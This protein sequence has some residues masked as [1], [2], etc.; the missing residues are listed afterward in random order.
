MNVSLLLIFLG[1]PQSS[2]FLPRNGCEYGYTHENLH[3]LEN[4]FR[5]RFTSISSVANPVVFDYEL[6]SSVL[7]RSI[8]NKQRSLVVFDCELTLENV[9]CS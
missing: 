7:C 4:C 3:A 5:S 1:E 6:K 9:L 2:Q 8:Q